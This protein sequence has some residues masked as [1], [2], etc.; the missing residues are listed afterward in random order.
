[1]LV[2][3][4]DVAYACAGVNGFNNK[5]KVYFAENKLIVVVKHEQLMQPPGEMMYEILHAA[6]DTNSSRI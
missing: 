4:I 2:H 3:W 6:E 5:N 1:M